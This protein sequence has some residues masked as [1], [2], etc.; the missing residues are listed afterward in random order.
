M[1]LAVSCLSIFSI[2]FLCGCVASA[3]GDGLEET[4]VRDANVDAETTM[5]GDAATAPDATPITA[6]D[7]GLT[8]GM[9]GGIA[10]FQCKIDGDYCRMPINMCIEVSDAAGVCAPKP[11]ACT[12]EYRPVC[13]C[14]GK[15]YANACT[16]KAE[17]VNILA[18]FSACEE[19]NGGQFRQ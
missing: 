5:A 1:R 13:G 11:S 7:I 9:C 14:D 15:T 2:L 3:Q 6:V 10:G 18:D 19:A 8:G 17:G 16:A 12:R 4:T